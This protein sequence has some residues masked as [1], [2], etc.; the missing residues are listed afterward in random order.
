M[1]PE[2]P[3][4][5]GEFARRS[6]LPAS[7]LRY[8]DQIGLLRPARVDP[9]SGY[10]Y[11]ESSQLRAAALVQELRQLRVRP[12]VIAAI[13]D[14]D[15]P[16]ALLQEER[17]RI[18]GEI[19]RRLGALDRL[20]RLLEAHGSQRRPSVELWERPAGRHAALRGTMRVEHAM[21][22][23]R[24]LLATLRSRLRDAGGP[25]PLSFGAVLPLD[26]DHDPVPVTVYSTDHGDARHGADLATITIPAGL[27]AGVVYEGHD[28]WARAYHALF[29]FA[30]QHG[31]EPRGPVIEEYLAAPDRPRTRLSVALG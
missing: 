18:A 19:D 25:R 26:L 6:R 27:Y 20:D 4:S 1:S 22:D 12:E 8:Y 10:R 31:H 5:I 11:Y 2:G 13:L 7:T 17:A 28:G 16:G 15:E 24:R 14:A 30:S 9:N 23:V 21:T 3:W 29:S